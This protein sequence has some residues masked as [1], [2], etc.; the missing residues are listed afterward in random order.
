[1]GEGVCFSPGALAL[2]GACWVV[3]QG[4]I[5]T[6]F[7][8]LINAYRSQIAKAELREAEWKRVAVRGAN[9]IIPSLATELRGRL[10][11]DIRELQTLHEGADS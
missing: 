2:L 8:L 4:T 7:W 1:M 5:V 9:E 11:A 10:Q 6:I 3:I